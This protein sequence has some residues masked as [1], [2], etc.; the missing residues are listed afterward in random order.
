MTMKKV[1]M[2]LVSVFALLA[3]ATVCSAQVSL[4]SVSHF[5]ADC[6][7]LLTGADTSTQTA[8]C[9]GSFI[10]SAATITFQLNNVANFVLM[11]PPGTDNCALKAGTATITT[12]HNGTINMTL[13]GAGC[14]TAA[15]TGTGRFAEAYW[16]QSGTGDFST[17]KGSGSFS[18]GFDQPGGQL[19]IHIDGNITVPTEEGE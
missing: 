3:G 10:G 1:V 15:S 6:S 11:P 14:A 8:T 19:L 13:G 2:S 18:V 16:I 17:A 9:K 7:G 4:E 12:H 5:H